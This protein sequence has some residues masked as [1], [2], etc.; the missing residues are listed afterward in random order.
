MIIEQ[1]RAERERQ[2]DSCREDRAFSFF[3]TN[4][5]MLINPFPSG[6]YA[7]YSDQ[8]RGR[9]WLRRWKRRRRLFFILKHIARSI[10]HARGE[11]GVNKQVGN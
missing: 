6:N 4:W 10:L 5:A 8:V 2:R 11:F 1:S 7:E 3:A 9:L